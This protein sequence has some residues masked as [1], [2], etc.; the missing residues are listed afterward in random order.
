MS[1]SWMYGM[2]RPTSVCNVEKKKTG[3]P[4]VGLEFQAK[5]IEDVESSS[6]RSFHQYKYDAMNATPCY[7]NEFSLYLTRHSRSAHHLVCHWQNSAHSTVVFP[8]LCCLFSFRKGKNHRGENFLKNDPWAGRGTFFLKK[9]KT[10]ACR[11]RLESVRLVKC[12]TRYRALFS[13]PFSLCPLS[14]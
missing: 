1:Q 7:R 5:V 6:F 9:K 3:I 4:A 8:I 2:K 11:W 14:V 12:E 10:L 13:I